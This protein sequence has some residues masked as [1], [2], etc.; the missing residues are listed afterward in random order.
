MGRRCDPRHRRPRPVPA[1]VLRPESPAL[2]ILQA[3][4]RH[5]RLRQPQLFALVEERGSPQAGQRR[6]QHLGELPRRL[7]AAPA[8]NHPLD[9][10]VAE[11]PRRPGVRRRRQQLL[12]RTADVRGAQGL[13]QEH[14]A[15]GGVVAV[16]TVGVGDHRADRVVAGDLGHRHA[17]RITVHQFAKAGD[18]GQGLR[19]RAVVDLALQPV[20][21]DR[22]GVGKRRIVAEQ[23]IVDEEV[24]DVETKAV[25]AALEPKPRGV[26]DFVL[27][28]R[29]VEV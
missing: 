9:V 21:L 19:P 16:R 7:A 27:D 1:L 28:L 12:N 20:G 2:R 11:R 13:T 10:V 8:G 22:I 14:E 4:E 5:F 15:V 29:V 3:L 23:R 17:P 26:E 25:D 24:G 6:D 18:E